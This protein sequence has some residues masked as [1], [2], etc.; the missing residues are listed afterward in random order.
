[1]RTLF[2]R[3]DAERRSPSRLAALLDAA[4]FCICLLGI[5]AAI[6]GNFAGRSLYVDEAMVV[7]SILTRSLRGLAGSPLPY[8]QTAPVLW[9]WIVKAVT[10]AFGSSEVALRSFSVV[11]YAA[12][13][14]LT[15]WTAKRF[16]GVRCPW[17]AAAFLANMLAFL[18][19]ANVVKPYE[20]EAVCVLAVLAAEGFR[21]EG[22]LR[23]PAVAGIW[24]AAMLGGNPPVFFAAACLLHEGVGALRARDRRR[25]VAVAGAGAAVLAVFAAYWAWWLRGTAGSDFMQDWWRN[26]ML[27]VRPPTAETFARDVRI[28]KRC[29]FETVFGARAV[30]VAWLLAG[31]VAMAWTGKARN[32]RLLTT[33]LMLAL[34]ASAMHRFPVDLRLWVFSFP[35]VAIL[36]VGLLCDAMDG[37]AAWPMAILMSLLV[38]G[39]F[40]IP[41]HFVRDNVYWNGE[42][43]NPLLDYVQEHLQ[44]GEWVYVTDRAIPGLKYHLGYDFERFGNDGRDNVIWGGD[45]WG[46]NPDLRA[47]AD[48][49]EAA[50]KC[51]LVLVPVVRSKTGGLW[52]RLERTGRIEKVFE[53]QGTPL[54][55]YERFPV[56]ATE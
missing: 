56:T 39:Q 7:H 20:F 12:A 30:A 38:A 5:A 33:P 47:D 6:H 14:G 45:T 54:Y 36:L 46:K 10:M 22:K 15:A 8:N 26:Q 52:A 4:G 27:S 37:R 3:L 23:W 28:V 34:V 18:C 35:V 43:L 9:L 55:C 51:W 1:M 29:Y 2:P 48:R 25:L 24:I 17:M 44:D 40:G 16:F 50:G 31:A 21:R 19:Y 53:F 32:R 42:E 41:R 13:L 49:I 11:S